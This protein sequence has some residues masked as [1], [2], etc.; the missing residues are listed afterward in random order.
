MIEIPGKITIL[1]EAS[2]T[3]LLA[4]D[5]SKAEEFANKAIDLYYPEEFPSILKQ[6]QSLLDKDVDWLKRII[7]IEL[8]ECDVIVEERSNEYKYSEDMLFFLPENVVALIIMSEIQKIQNSDEYVGT[9]KKIF[10]C[11][12]AILSK[13]T[14]KTKNLIESEKIIL[15]LI[16][17]LT[18]KICLSIT[19]VLILKN[20]NL[21]VDKMFKR[22]ISCNKGDKD[23]LYTY[24][25]YLIKVGNKKEAAKLWQTFR[26]EKSIISSLESLQ[27]LSLR[28][29]LTSK[30]SILELEE[31]ERELQIN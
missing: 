22:G 26:N 27:S 24:C 7:E 31:L 23:V 18:S 17:A 13:L 14:T 1:H 4:G 2:I 3:N 29:I 20:D 30:V 6:N 16:K 12:S 21:N 19:E 10:H 9:L 15:I 11:F 28:Y 25:K 8:L 5:L